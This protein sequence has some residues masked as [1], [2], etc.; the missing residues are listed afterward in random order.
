MNE[1]GRG[2]VENGGGPTV[3]SN[4]LAE[5]PRV[6]V[7][8]V[9]SAEGARAAAAALT[10]A[11]AD[12]DRATLLV[13]VGGRPPRPTLLASAAARA[14]EERLA[15][16]LPSARVA[17]RGQVCHLAVAAD[18]EGFELAG[19]ALTAGRE[20]LVALHV[21]P[22]VVQPLLA[23]RLG[24]CLSAALLR[25]D[26]ATDRALLALVVADLRGRGLTVGVLKRRLAWVAERRA[27]F[28]TLAPGAGLP[29]A[30]ADRLSGPELPSSRRGKGS[31]EAAEIRAARY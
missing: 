10:C 9:G 12:V 25:A 17:A 27:L 3:F 13:D 22:E 2:A 11:G 23:A 1:G 24:A 16:H 31:S 7:S 4:P 5:A 8:A 6:L 18:A 29:P 26:I 15:A 21:P 20:S 28:G 19:A 30:L 14:L